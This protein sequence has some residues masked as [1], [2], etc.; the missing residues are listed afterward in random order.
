MYRSMLD[1]PEHKHHDRRDQ[2]LECLCRMV[3]DLELEVQG[4]RQQRNHDEHA[5]GFVSVRGS[6]R[7]ASHQSGSRRS[8]DYVDKDSISF[9]GRR[10][11]NAALGAIS[12][13]LRRATRSPFL[14]EIER[15][16]MSSKFTRPPFISYDWKID[17]VEHVC[18][19]IHMTSLHNHNDALMCMVFPSS[20][21][22]RGGSTG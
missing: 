9:E 13:A 1:V 15:A 21:R 8:R 5:E 11:R 16:P 19:Y 18:H 17:S 20:L 22:P 6:H 4:R 3:R 10:P 7:E 12:R 14:E 2:E